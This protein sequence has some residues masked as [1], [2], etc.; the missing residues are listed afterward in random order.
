M[1]G[2]KELLP[3]K[4]WNKHIYIASRELIARFGLDV[5]QSFLQ[6]WTTKPTD[7]QKIKRS[8][9]RFGHKQKTVHH[10]CKSGYLSEDVCLISP[11]TSEPYRCIVSNCFANLHCCHS[12]ILYSGRHLSSTE[13]VCASASQCTYTCFINKLQIVLKHGFTIV[14]DTAPRG[15]LWFNQNGSFRPPGTDG[16]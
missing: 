6:T 7:N 1:E 12:P 4:H 3:L 16:R 8:I 2:T 13:E 11:G 5:R 15:H 14:T 10:Q 9:P